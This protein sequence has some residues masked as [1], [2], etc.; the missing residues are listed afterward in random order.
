MVAFNKKGSYDRRSKA[1]KLL[2]QKLIDKFVE[3][4]PGAAIFVEKDL[5]SPPGGW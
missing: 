3:F 5:T 4:L 2:Y 1:C